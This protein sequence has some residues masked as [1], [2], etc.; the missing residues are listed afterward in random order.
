MMNMLS[1]NHQSFHIFSPSISLKFPQKVFFSF[2]T[3]FIDLIPSQ[4]NPI[5]DLTANK[6]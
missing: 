5:I 4:I 6:F 1:I 2:Q 3:P